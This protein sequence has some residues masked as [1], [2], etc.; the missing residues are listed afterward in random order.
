MN[1]R[2]LLFAIIAVTIFAIGVISWFFFYAT[3][4]TA[5]TLSGTN[6]PLSQKKYPKGFQFIFGN[7]EEKPTQETTTEVTFKDKEILT[8]IWDKPATGQTFVDTTFVT[9]VDATSTKGTTTVMVKKLSYATTTLLMFVDRTTGYIYS[10][11]RTIGKI[12][13]ISNTTIPGIYDAYIFNNGKNILL[14]HPDNDKHTIISLVATIPEVNERM[15][16]KPLESIS[17]LPSQVKSVAVNKKTGDIAYLVAGEKNA[18]IYTISKNTKDPVLV[19]TTPF[20]EWDLSYADN[21]LFATTKPSAY[22]EGQTVLIPS[23]DFILGGKTG[24]MS[25]PGPSGIFIASMWSNTGLKTFLSL[26][27]QQSV[28][29]IKTLASKC[30]WGDKKLLLCAVPNTL[31]K[32]SEGLPDDWFQ[33]RISFNDTFYKINTATGETSTYY[34]FDKEVYGEFDINSLTFSSNNTYSS[35]TRKQDATLWLLDDSLMQ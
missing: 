23:F 34:A 20:S 6:D 27:G 3:P 21:D 10:Y 35:F 24:L 8:K 11:N 4:K 33:G 25:N 29:S 9:E 5:P 13:Q 12:Y 7:S 31:P 2:K 14:R 18:A 30:F 15:D 32:K 22:V 1:N 28:L 26:Y 17:N 16:P 19:S